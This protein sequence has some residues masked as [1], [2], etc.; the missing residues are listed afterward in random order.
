MALGQ[1][2]VAQS[3]KEVFSVLALTVVLMA[4]HEGLVACED[5]RIRRWMSRCHLLVQLEL[6]ARKGRVRIDYRKV[7]LDF[8]VP[9]EIP[10]AADSPVKLEDL[11][12]L[13]IDG[14]KD[15]F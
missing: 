12:V 5:D 6:Q 8:V 2:G 1:L 14:D 4:C 15:A 11:N 9:G 7:T 13:F 3:S 10:L